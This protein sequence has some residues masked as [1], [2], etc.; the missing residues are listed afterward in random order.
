MGPYC[1]G[2]SVLGCLIHPSNLTEEGTLR[3]AGTCPHGQGRTCCS[4]EADL[5]HTNEHETRGALGPE[6]VNR[7]QEPEVS[8]DS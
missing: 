4:H 7:R 8:L 5:G 6:G 1:G 2:D 3:L